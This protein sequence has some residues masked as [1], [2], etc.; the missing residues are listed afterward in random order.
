MQVTAGACNIPLVLHGTI[1]LL[2]SQLAGYAFFRALAGAHHDSARTGMWRMSH[3]ACSAGAIFLIALGPV[4]PHLS[5]VPL[6]AAIVVDALIA[7]TYALCL[8]TVVAGWSGQRGIRP[9]GPRSNRAVYVLYLAG[10]LGSTLSGL[11][12]LWGATR[13]Y[14]AP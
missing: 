4:L 5:L 2:L 3:A 9:G 8:G 7:S 6:P 12:L 13:A 1:V 10:A 11:A 14:F